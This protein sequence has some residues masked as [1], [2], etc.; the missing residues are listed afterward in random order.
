MDDVE[1]YR[2]LIETIRDVEKYQESLLH[3][4]FSPMRPLIEEKLVTL[5]EKRHVLASSGKKCSCCGGSGRG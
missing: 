4:S 2:K 3:G 1:L 5:I